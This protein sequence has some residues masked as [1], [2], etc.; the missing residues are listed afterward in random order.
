[1]IVWISPITGAMLG[2]EWVQGE[3]CLVIDLVIVRI[4]LDFNL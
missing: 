1:M 4:M 3:N 2:I